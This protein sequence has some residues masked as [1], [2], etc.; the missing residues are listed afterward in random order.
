MYEE[1]QSLT[2]DNFRQRFSTA[3]QC[4]D[5]IAS[6]KWAGGYSCKQCGHAKYCKGFA[7]GSRQCTRCNKVESAKVNTLFQNMKIPLDKAFYMLYLIVTD[8][9]GSPSTQLARQTGLTQKT[10]L[11]FHRK[12]MAAMA[13]T[14]RHPLEGNVDVVE[15]VVD[16]IRRDKGKKPKF[17]QAR[18]LIGIEKKGGGA[19]RS[20][21]SV[22]GHASKKRSQAFITRKIDGR[23]MI[24]MDQPAQLCCYGQQTSG[25]EGLD[26]ALDQRV[27]RNML[28]WLYARHGYVT[29]LQD[30]LNEYCYRYNRHRMKGEILDDIITRMVR[31]KPMT[32]RFMVGS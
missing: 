24:N 7:Y 13:S 22:I 18:I 27:V 21:V 5:Y 23:A 1:L 14:D 32:Q 6:V 31:H 30:Y 26:K 17:K 8:K 16:I 10:C 12:V 25:C 2:I 9:K 19:A 28:N 20:Y 29:Y 11:M 4:I 15:V 3:E